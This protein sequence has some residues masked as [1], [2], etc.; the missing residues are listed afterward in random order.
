MVDGPKVREALNYILKYWAICT[1]DSDG[2][3]GGMSTTWNP[4]KS[5]LTT[6]Q[7]SVGIVLEGKIKNCS[8]DLKIINC[9]RSY[10][11]RKYFW[12]QVHDQ[13]LLIDSYAILGG[14]LNLIVYEREV[15][16][17]HA[18]SDSLGPYFKSFFE[19]NKMVDVEPLP[20][21]QTL[22]NSRTGDN[23]VAKRLDIFWIAKSFLS[24]VRKFRSLEVVDYIS[25]HSP[26]VLHLEFEI[27]RVGYPF[28][29][30]CNWIGELD[31][32]DLI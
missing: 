7:D 10:R 12:K 14:D 8:H 3:S 1:I 29:F 5:Y 25:D 15:L 16:G 30:N 18:I 9:Y 4:L 13:G 26:I 6:Y 20:L 19:S 28:K 32:N 23:Y 11:N 24:K 2:L 22:I 31:F 17:S 27:E 21:L